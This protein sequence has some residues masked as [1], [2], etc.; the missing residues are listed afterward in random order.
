MTAYPSPKFPV[1]ILQNSVKMTN[2]P[3]KGIRANMKRSLLLEP[4][5]NPEFF[6]GCSK[7]KVGL[8]SYY[9]QYID[10]NIDITCSS[11]SVTDSL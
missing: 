11:T 2:E 1:T 3:P 7:P 6:D 4:I 8:G 9:S 5:C 10:H